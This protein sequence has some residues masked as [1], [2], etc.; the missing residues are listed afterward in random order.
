MF[1]QFSLQYSRLPERFYQHFEPAPV[2][3]PR[4]IAF[5]RGLAEQL[6]FDLSAYPGDDKAAEYFAGNLIPP[7][8]E[9]LAQAYAGHQFGGFVPQLGDGRAVLLGEVLDRNGCLRDIQLKGAGRTPF[10]RGGDGRAPLGPVLREYVVSEAMH[11]LGIPTTRALAAVSTGEHVYREIPM[12]GGILTRVA[13]S[14]IRVGTF[15]Y[16][17]ARGDLEGLKRLADH[18]IARHYPSLASL[19][20]DQRYLA[21]VENVQLQQARLIARWMGVGFIHG[22]M[23]TDN[24]STAGET[25]DYGPC[26]FMEKYDPRT[27][28]SSIDQNG[29][30]AYGNQPA[31]GQWN[32]ARFAETLLPLIDSDQHRAIERATELIQRFPAL[33]RA[34]WLAV[35]RAK[36]GLCRDDKEDFALA[37]ALLAAMHS[38]RADFTLTFRRLCDCAE[39]P[40]HDE[41][42]LALFEQAQAVEAWLPRWRERLTEE[43]ASAA[44]VADRM[45]RTNPFYIPRNH[46]VEHM[47]EAAI[48]RDDYLPLHR[49]N[50][51]LARPFDEQPGRERYAQPATPQEQVYRTFCGT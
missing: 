45:R 19:A 18:V 44:E 1:P 51:V 35:M 49:L 14:H 5:N 34:E 37:E 48:E 32:I 21:L 46:L 24:T 26:A 43:P 33:Y 11:A 50:E 40:A 28:F 36:L 9:P 29:R 23:N 38:G 10:S 30:Y 39:S 20:D 47:I 12:P 27:V 13:A 15:E 17:A 31:I 41:P 16:F 2:K 7:G 42:L 25:I 22:V 3:R 4:L 6:G 8:A